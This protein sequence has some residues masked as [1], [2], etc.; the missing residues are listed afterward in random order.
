MGEEC[1]EMIK[2]IYIA[3]NSLIAHKPFEKLKRINDQL[4]R[5][6]AY[7]S[8]VVLEFYL[9]IDSVELMKEKWITTPFLQD[10]L[11]HA[12]ISQRTAE[13]A[14][15]CHQFSAGLIGIKM[16]SKEALFILGLCL[17]STCKYLI[18]ISE[19]QTIPGMMVCRSDGKVKMAEI[20]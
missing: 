11:H 18:E 9:L 4:L 12:L 15:I 20:C 3:P 1:F 19:T 2:D 13:Y 6:K 10:F 17:F 16:D 5:E 8:Q 14:I 7:H